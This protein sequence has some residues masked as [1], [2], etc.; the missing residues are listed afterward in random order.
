MFGFA[1]RVLLESLER[2][3][4]ATADAQPLATA[5]FAALPD[6]ATSVTR[7]VA[8]RESLDVFARHVDGLPRD[9]QRLLLYRGLEERPH[10]EVARLLDTT[11]EAAAKRWQRLRDRLSA[12]LVEVD[13]LAA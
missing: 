1:R 6:D 12:E 7:S 5:Q 9:D 3:S 11:P 4:S 13:F 8:R 10:D 2:A